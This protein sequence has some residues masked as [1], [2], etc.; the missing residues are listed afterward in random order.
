[1]VMSR[2][3]NEA[4]MGG[5]FGIGVW[6]LGF[7][8]WGLGFGV[9]GLGLRSLAA[10]G[11]PAHVHADGPGATLPQPVQVKGHAIAAADVARTCTHA[12]AHA[13]THA[14]VHAHLVTTASA[15]ILNAGGGTCTKRYN[16]TL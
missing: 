15:S 11:E 12:H 1:M 14:H 10:V 13:H 16:N 5:W 3:A 6:G 8:V 9:W 2:T 7:G 4:T